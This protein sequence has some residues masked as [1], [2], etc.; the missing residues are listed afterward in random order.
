[1][2]RHH[3]FRQD[4]LLDELVG[5]PRNAPDNDVLGLLM[6]PCRH[7]TPYHAPLYLAQAKGFFK[8]EG[9]K[10]AL[11]EPNDPSVSLVVPNLGGGPLLLMCFSVGCHRDNRNRQGR[12]WFQGHDPHSGRE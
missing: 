4:H 5:L 12:P 9:I 7:A 1:M 10:V 11:L 8:E 6:S 3:V 2:Q